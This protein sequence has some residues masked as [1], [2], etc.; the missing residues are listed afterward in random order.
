MAGIMLEVSIL[1]VM[2]IKPV[3]AKNRNTGIII[4]PEEVVLIQ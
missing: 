4:I 2:E 3:L 1:A